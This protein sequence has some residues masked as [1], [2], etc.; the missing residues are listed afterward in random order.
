ML[1]KSRSEATEM[2]EA[3]GA[4]GGAK[5]DKQE[6]DGLHGPCTFVTTH[7]YAAQGRVLFGIVAPREGVRGQPGL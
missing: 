3:N 2:K 6:G 1:T 4:G 7:P 5:E